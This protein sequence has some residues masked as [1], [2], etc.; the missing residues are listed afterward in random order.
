MTP[1][2]AADRTHTGASGA[3]LLPEL[4]TRTGDFRAG[5]HLVGARALR[6]RILPDRFV[7][8]RFVDF[9]AEDFVRQLERA[10]LLIIQI[11]NINRW[12]GVTSWTSA[13]AHTRRW[14][15]EPRPSPRA[16]CPRAPHRRLPGCGPSPWHRPCDRPCA[17]QAPRA[18]ESSTR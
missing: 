1:D 8:Q 15:Q 18:T 3:L 17:Y 2:R 13:P 16:R 5:L 14:G 10:D 6:C 11:K 9:G 7:Q 12:H 4:L